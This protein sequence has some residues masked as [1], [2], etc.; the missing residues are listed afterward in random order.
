M[1]PAA[2]PGPSASA[3][4][5][6]VAVFG[7]YDDP[8]RAG[9]PDRAPQPAAPFG[10]PPRREDRGLLGRLRRGRRDRLRR[11]RR[12]RR[13]AATRSRDRGHRARCRLRQ[14]AHPARPE[15]QG[16]H[17]K[18]WSLVMVSTDYGRRGVPG[19][20]SPASR[21]EVPATSTSAS[22]SARAR[23]PPWHCAGA[24]SVGVRSLQPPG[25]RRGDAQPR[26]AGPPARAP[27]PRGAIAG[28]GLQMVH[29]LT[30]VAAVPAGLSRSRP[31]LH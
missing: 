27:G 21:R 10:P 22:G 31:P 20:A 9:A 24:S 7:S 11:R 8:S 26:P 29:Q 30:A 25:S 12:L 2:A 6:P 17:L 15:I 16:T 23:W 1:H 14:R 3:R 13:R 28:V 5:G 18:E 19:A 4:S